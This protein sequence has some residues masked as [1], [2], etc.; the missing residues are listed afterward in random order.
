[1]FEGHPLVERFN[2]FS[3]EDLCMTSTIDLSK[4]SFEHK[5][6]GFALAL[7][8]A[9]SVPQ[10]RLP[11]T[12]HKAVDMA[13]G[14]IKAR[15][16]SCIRIDHGFS[17]D[18]RSESVRGAWHDFL[19]HIMAAGVEIHLASQMLPSESQL[20]SQIIRRLSQRSDGSVLSE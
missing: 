8:Q 5:P 1:M 15:G 11:K 10:S 9:L 6:R 4:Y 18:Q 14:L 13:L 3:F 7:L 19:R 12:T 17:I 20:P 2:K 16:I